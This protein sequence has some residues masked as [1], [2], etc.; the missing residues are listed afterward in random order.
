[1]KR[2]I[3]INFVRNEL[4]LV[5]D[6]VKTWNSSR[7]EACENGENDKTKV[8]DKTKATK[9]KQTATNSKYFHFTHRKH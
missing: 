7:R 1:M 9:P 6:T 4:G 3:H 2:E 8:R 5:S